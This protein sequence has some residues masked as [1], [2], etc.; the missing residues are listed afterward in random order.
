MSTRPET[1]K[2]LEMLFGA[3]WNLPKAA[4]NASLSP[5]EMK[6]I[7][8]EYCEMHPPTYVPEDK[9]AQ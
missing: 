9:V 7:F 8:N 3:Q 6:I 2:S 5:K 1:R 4:E